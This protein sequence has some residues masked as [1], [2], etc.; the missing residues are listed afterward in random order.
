MNGVR[1]G[2]KFLFGAFYASLIWLVALFSVDDYSWM[3]PIVIMLVILS[4]L[5]VSM[6]G[7]WAI[8]NL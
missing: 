3:I 6:V 2:A 7:Q 5:L 1:N 4:I 8:N